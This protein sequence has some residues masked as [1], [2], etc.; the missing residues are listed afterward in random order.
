ML[1]LSCANSGGGEKTIKHMMFQMIEWLQMKKLHF[2]FFCIRP[3]ETY[4]GFGTHFTCALLSPEGQEHWISFRRKCL[5]WA[6]GHSNSSLGGVQ[7]WEWTPFL[8]VMEVGSLP[9]ALAWLGEI[10]FVP[11]WSVWPIFLVGEITRVVSQQS[12]CFLSPLPYTLKPVSFRLKK[13]KS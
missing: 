3:H 1:S 7:K 9:L 11:S 4:V 5:R 8:L 6:L 10:I 12:L 13:R 2:P